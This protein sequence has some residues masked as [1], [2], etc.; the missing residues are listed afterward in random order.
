MAEVAKWAS[1]AEMGES[2]RF[3]AQSP[4]YPYS[5]GKISTLSESG[6]DQDSGIED[7]RFSKNRV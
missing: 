3:Q 2:K 6:I 5:K 1:T 7:T 4:G